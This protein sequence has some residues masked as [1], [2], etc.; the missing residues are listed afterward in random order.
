MSGPVDDTL[1]I[2]WYTVNN[3]DQGGCYHQDIDNQ[4]S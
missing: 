2:M 4:T 3:N 1:S